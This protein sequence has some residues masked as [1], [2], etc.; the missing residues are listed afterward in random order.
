M[1]ADF[2]KWASKT[3]GESLFCLK[4]DT[5]MRQHLRETADRADRQQ[6]G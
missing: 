5:L 4:E 6:R 3:F 1:I 2:R